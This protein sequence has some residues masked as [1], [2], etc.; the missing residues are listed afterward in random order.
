MM[1]GGR[2]IDSA[3]EGGTF[4]CQGHGGGDQIELLVSVWEDLPGR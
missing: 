2:L 1:R 3:L 4:N